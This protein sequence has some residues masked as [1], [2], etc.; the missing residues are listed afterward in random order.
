MSGILVF[1]E[2]RDGTL[3]RAALEA[4]SEG[5][6]LGAELGASVT[7]V[8]VGS[9]VAALADELASFGAQKVVVAEDPSLSTYATE[10]FARVVTDAARSGGA[11]VILFPFTAMGKDLA[12]RV[13]A[14][15]DAGLTSDCVALSANSGR[16]EALRPMYAGKAYA[17][18][19]FA[20]AIQVATLRPNVFA[21][22]APQAGRKADVVKAATPSPSRAR[23]V[24]VEQTAAGKIELAEAQAVVSGGR[25]LKGPEH[26]HL[27]EELAQALGAA[28]GASRAVVDAGWVGHHSQVG[29]TGKVVS[30]NLYVACGISGA[31]QH[32]AGMSSSKTIVAI[33]KD[34]EAPIFKA[35]TYGVVGDLFEVLPRLTEAVKT[36]RAAKG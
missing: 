19:A 35:A 26:F 33:N 8:V 15:L 14:R 7:A 25:G 36:Q 28:V 13:A 10:A 2:Q 32:L 12:P 34:P 20:S 6:R 21:L 5:A 24:S 23:V 30:P 4:L 27:V 11:D 16:I 9:S 29:Q 22:A 3:R 1:A 18:V 17:K 31:I